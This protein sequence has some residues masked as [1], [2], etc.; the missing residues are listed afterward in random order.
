MSINMNMSIT[1][2]DV[3]LHDDASAGHDLSGN[4]SD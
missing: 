1:V 2:I 3:T 4:D